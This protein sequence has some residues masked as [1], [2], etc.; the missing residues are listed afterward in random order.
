MK[1]NSLVALLIGAIFS[2]LAIAEQPQI[3][4]GQLEGRVPEDDARAA[5]LAGK[6]NFLGVAGFS[7]TVP[8]IDESNCQVAR[9]FVDIIP[10]T[11]DVIS[12]E[13]R[14]VSLSLINSYAF[15]YN[16]YM[17]KYRKQ[18]IIMDCQ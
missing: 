18:K 15:R 5:I 2:T 12:F 11:S 1:Q 9:Q 8:G 7:L 3:S 10:G 6:L 4:V 14:G 13:N 16:L 17:K